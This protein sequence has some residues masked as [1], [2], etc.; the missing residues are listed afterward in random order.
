MA[1]DLSL[2]APRSGVANELDLLDMVD[3]DEQYEIVRYFAAKH[4]APYIGGGGR[5]PDA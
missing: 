5:V 4:I 1:S 3:E 2:I